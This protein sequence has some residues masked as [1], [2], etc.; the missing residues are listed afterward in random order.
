LEQ[1]PQSLTPPVPDF[2]AAD[3]SLPGK[4]LLKF[5]SC[6]KYLLSRR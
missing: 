1:I 6:T 3:R 5:L 2:T 4:F